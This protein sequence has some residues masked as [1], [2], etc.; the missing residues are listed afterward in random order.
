MFYIEEQKRGFYP[1]EN[2][3][4]VGRYEIEIKPN[5]EK[6]ISFVCS[7]EENIDEL[8]VKKLIIKEK[9]RISKILE[10]QK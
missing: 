8:D 2:H 6:E 4:V 1:E 9:Q 7:L 3:A 5:E 10:K